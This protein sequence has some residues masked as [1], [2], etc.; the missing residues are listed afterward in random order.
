MP[1][2]TFNTLYSFESGPFYSLP[3]NLSRLPVSIRFVLESMLRNPMTLTTRVSA[4]V[5]P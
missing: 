2:N 1:P 5:S 4:L 3:A